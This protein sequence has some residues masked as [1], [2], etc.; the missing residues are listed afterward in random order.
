MSTDRHQFTIPARMTIADV[1]RRLRAALHVQPDPVSTLHVTYLD[2]FDWRIFSR[3]DA[4]QYERAGHDMRLIWRSLT[5]DTVYYSIPLTRRVQFASDLPDCPAQEKL[6]GILEMRMLLP[7]VELQIY[8]Q[9]LRL[10]DAKEKTILRLAVEDYH[11]AES[12]GA[13]KRAIERRIRVL[14]V[15]GYAKPLQATL[16]ILGS[17]WHLPDCEEDIW[18][19]ALLASGRKPLSYSAKL[20][21]QIDPKARSDAATKR[22]LLRLLDIMQANETGA[23]ADLD[24]EF[25]HDFRVAVRKSRTALAQIKGVFPQ[26]VVSR[27]RREF[28]WLGRITG[29][30]RDLDVYLLKFDE[31]KASLPEA[32]RADLD[33]LHEFLQTHQRSEQQAL[34]KAL[35][36]RRYHTLVSAWRRFLEAPVPQRTTL[37]NAARPVAA[38]SADRIWHMYRRVAKEGSAIH[39]D[40]PAETYHEVRKSCK[41]LRYL[42]EFFESIYP[43]KEIRDLIKSLKLLQENLGDFQDL[44]VQACAM[45]D[46]ARRMTEESKVPPAAL[47]AMGILVEGLL[48]RQQRAKEEFA[49]RFRRFNSNKN[50]RLFAALFSIP[51]KDVTLPS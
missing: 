1:V 47:M 51:E 38:L 37:R 16:R 35:D 43:T 13:S 6:A 23:R 49:T 44:A 29:N 30:T 25:L 40:S 32:L 4:L 48:A 12:Q 21:L 31:Y 22:I 42:I 36:S 18:E 24:A 19:L 9:M 2:S 3:G 39:D 14:P 15:K 5:T 20:H 8:R 41:K 33:P 50:Q 46:F 28:S 7:T 45:Q 11:L 34:A 17:E 27:F 26:S 10:L